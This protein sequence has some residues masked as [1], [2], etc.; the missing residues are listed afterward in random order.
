MVGEGY[1]ARAYTIIRREND[2]K[3]LVKNYTPVETD[4][5]EEVDDKE[6]EVKGTLPTKRTKVV[7]KKGCEASL[8]KLCQWIGTVRWCCN[9]CVAFGRNHPDKLKQ[10]SGSLPRNLRDNIKSMIP[11]NPWLKDCPSDVRYEAILEYCKAIGINQAKAQK[12]RKQGIPF[13]FKMGFRRKSEAIN[14]TIKIRSINWGIGEQAFLVN[15][16]T[17]NEMDAIPKKVLRAVD[18]TKTGMGLYFNFAEGATLDTS[19]YRPH[20]IVALD[21]GVRTFMTG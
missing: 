15:D 18:I 19:T 21:P 13:S 14:E 8:E 4:T 5:D 7:L 10:I 6:T 3:F 9:Q 17:S 12:M 20:E 11:T 1:K 16:Y 2:I